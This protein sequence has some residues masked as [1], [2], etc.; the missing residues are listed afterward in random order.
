MDTNSKK[1]KLSKKEA[2]EQRKLEKLAKLE[3]SRILPPEVAQSPKLPDSLNF[4]DGSNYQL[5][6]ERYN[7]NQCGIHNLSGEEPKHLIQKLSRITKLNH[8]TLLPS[9]IIKD[10][11]E[12]TGSYAPLFDGL[13]DDIELKEIS[14]TKPGRIFCYFLTQQKSENVVNNYCCV[15]AITPQH[16]RA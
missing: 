15:I 2:R 14:F 1:Q 11:V 5:I 10:K 3:H 16:L 13:E 8:K 12:K 7:H 4:L 6:F 9:G